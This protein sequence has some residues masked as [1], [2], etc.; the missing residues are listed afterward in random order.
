MSLTFNGVKVSIADDNL[1]MDYTK[2]TVTSITADWTKTQKKYTVLESAVTNTDPAT[3][4]SNIVTS[5]STS[6]Q[7]DINGKFDTTG[8]NFTA[9]ADLT[10]LQTNVSR[11]ANLFHTVAEYY[12]YVNIYVRED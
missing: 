11:G 6:A 10:A 2:P 1:P 5:L 8:S 9:Y 12:A 4:I 7:A 3:V